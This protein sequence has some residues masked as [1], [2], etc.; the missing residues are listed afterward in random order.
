MA[1]AGVTEAPSW[2][3]AAIARAANSVA[4]APPTRP[5]LDQAIAG[6]R[7]SNSIIAVISRPALV[8]LV[9]MIVAQRR[10]LRPC[11]ERSL[12]EARP[13]G[14]RVPF[15]LKCCLSAPA[16]S[17]VIALPSLERL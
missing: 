13:Q 5:R 1:C 2:P 8:P 7:A 12:G 14:A 6:P 11:P 3:P 10:S 9:R 16:P 15:Q 4:A 17:P